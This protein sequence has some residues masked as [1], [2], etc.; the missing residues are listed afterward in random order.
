M[1]AWIEKLRQKQTDDWVACCLVR[2]KTRVYT[3]VASSPVLRMPQEYA[4]E[5][6]ARK[7]TSVTL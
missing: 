1:I 2:R 5:L 4:D 3:S 7:G 6:S